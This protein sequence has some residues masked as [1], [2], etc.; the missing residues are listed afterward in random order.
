MN[1]QLAYPSVW[2]ADKVLQFFFNLFRI[3]RCVALLGDR[4]GL[5]KMKSGLLE[6]MMRI[7]LNS[8][9]TP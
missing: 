7:L 3:L 8:S 9:W 4:E 2:D 6:S 1:E 5:R